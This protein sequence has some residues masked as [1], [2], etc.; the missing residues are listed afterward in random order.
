MYANILLWESADTYCH[1][2]LYCQENMF[3]SEN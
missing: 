3:L 2:L 1:V